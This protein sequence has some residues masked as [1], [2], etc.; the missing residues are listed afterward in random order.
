MNV[1]DDDKGRPGGRGGLEAVAHQVK[2]A[3]AADVG[4][5]LL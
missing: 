3:G 5:Q 1:F 4:R 2:K